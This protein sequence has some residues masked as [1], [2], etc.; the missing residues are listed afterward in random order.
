MTMNS[1]ACYGFSTRELKA[2]PESGRLA[3][4]CG[5]MNASR[6]RDKPEYCLSSRRVLVLTALR[7]VRKAAE[8]P[9]SNAVW[10]LH[11]ARPLKV[12]EVKSR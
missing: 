9:E 12:I 10:V 4:S 1:S 3:R 8:N 11:D 2:A 5:N 6:P 7:E